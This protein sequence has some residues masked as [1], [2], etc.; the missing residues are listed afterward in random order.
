MNLSCL[1][2][3]LDLLETKK[4][5]LP[6]VSN[7]FVAFIRHQMSFPLLSLKDV[8][9]YLETE[10]DSSPLGHIPF[11]LLETNEV[12]HCYFHFISWKLSSPLV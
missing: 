11:A 2:H 6:P 7:G 9:F 5:P 4:V 1:F 10:Q 3:F 12:L 8:V